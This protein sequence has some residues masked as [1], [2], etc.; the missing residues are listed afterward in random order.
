MDKR[1]FWSLDVYQC[2][3]WLW[4]RETPGGTCSATPTFWK[5]K[6]QN[7]YVNQNNWPKCFHVLHKIFKITIQV[8]S[9]HNK[10][11][12]GKNIMV[13]VLVKIKLK[14]LWQDIRSG[15]QKT[16]NPLLDLGIWLETYSLWRSSMFSSSPTINTL[17]LHLRQRFLL[18]SKYGTRSVRPQERRERAA[19]WWDLH[20]IL[21][22]YMGEAK[23]KKGWNNNNKPV[24]ITRLHKNSLMCMFWNIKLP[25]SIIRNPVNIDVLLPLVVLKHRLHLIRVFTGRVVSCFNGKNEREATV[26][27]FR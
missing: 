8:C 9:F 24:C 10:M 15:V 16:G 4:F 13:S 19:K 5:N 11:Q 18:V 3:S 23:T 1:T 2:P 14:S 17:I 12:L 20:Q 21:L 27:C 26:K 25:T 7:C 6:N 22:L